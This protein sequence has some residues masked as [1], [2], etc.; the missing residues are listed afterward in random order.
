MAKEL[1]QPVVRLG[2]EIDSKKSKLHS[3]IDSRE[4]ILNDFLL[5]SRKQFPMLP[6]CRSLLLKLETDLKSGWSKKIL[7]DSMIDSNPYVRPYS[8]GSDAD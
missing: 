6:K 5:I 4:S 2:I 8:V 7:K 1:T 3:K